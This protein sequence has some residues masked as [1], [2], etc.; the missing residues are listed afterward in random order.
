MQLLSLNVKSVGFP[1][2]LH[3]EI[4]ADFPSTVTNR[5]L[6]AGAVL[7]PEDRGS[8]SS[9][10]GRIVNHSPRDGV[11]THGWGYGVREPAEHREARQVSTKEVGCL[12]W[13]FWVGGLAGAEAWS[14]GAELW[15]ESG[16]VQE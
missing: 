11:D 2:L 9:L 4:I 6:Y 13:T 7:G 3:V 10:E 5:L 16:V 14:W 8:L 1:I 12:C 15:A